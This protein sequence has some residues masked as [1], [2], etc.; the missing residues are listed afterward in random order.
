MGW[1]PASSFSIRGRRAS[2]SLT[3]EANCHLPPG[4]G[5]A[6]RPPHGRQS[7]SAQAGHIHGPSR[8]AGR[9]GRSRNTSYAAGAVSGSRMGVRTSSCALRRPPFADAVLV[10][11]W[12]LSLVLGW[13]LPQVRLP[14]PEGA[15]SADETVS[16]TRAPDLRL[17][18]FNGLSSPLVGGRGRGPFHNSVCPGAIAAAV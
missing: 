15:A 16:A 13:W 18:G 8:A 7:R 1:R 5:V 14:T 11:R 4:R 17:F 12:P 10:H 3:E 9:T 2:T 6:V